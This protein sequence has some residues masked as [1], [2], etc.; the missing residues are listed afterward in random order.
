[1][2]RSKKKGI[3]RI[4]L[5]IL[6]A[7]LV[8]GLA[9]MP[10][11]AAEEEEDE[12]VASILSATATQSQLSTGIRGGGT[13][14]QQEAV[15]VSIPYDVLLTEFLV[16]NGDTVTEGQAVA[17]ADRV[18]VMSAIAQVQET[19]DYLD[20]EIQDARDSETSTT[21]SAASGGKVKAIYAQVGDD[22]QD[23]M[24]QY[25]ALAVLSLDA[26]MAVDIEKNTALAAG[27]SVVVTLPDESQV[28][29]WVES[30]L[31]GKLTVTLSDED[32]APGTYVLVTTNDGDR[33]GAGELY[34]HNAWYA[35]A[36]SGTVS[37]ISVSENATVSSGRT[38][39]TL[40]DTDYTA[41]FELL[42]AQRREY[43]EVMLELFQLYQSLEVTT[44]Q[45][46]VI[47]GVEEN[48]PSLLSDF[49][50]KAYLSLLA[51]AP[52]GDDSQEYNNYVTEVAAVGSEDW[53]LYVDPTNYSITDYKDLSGL[54]VDQTAMTELILYTCDAPIYELDSETGEWKQILSSDIG[55]GDVLLFAQTGE[56][57][58]VWIVRVTKA[59]RVD[60][61][62]D[63]PSDDDTSQ[64][65]PS[66]GGGMTGVTGGGST[67][68]T[69]V[70]LYSLERT[71][72][73]SVTGRET[74]TLSFSVDEMD[75]LDIYLGQS[76]TVQVDALGETCS[77]YVSDIGDTGESS[78]GNSKFTVTVT[79]DRTETMW[80][81][82]SA[83]V[84]VPLDQSISGL[85]IPV[86]ALNE[87]GSRTY[88]YT[89]YDEENGELTDPVEVQTGASDGEWV[90]IFSGLEEGD[91]IWYAYYDTL[92]I[93]TASAAGSTSGF[94]F[95]FGK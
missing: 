80:D 24:A 75:I 94:S 84:T 31:A 70:T 56:G 58:T 91:T 42:C 57:A 72:I 76:V 60:D 12:Y 83:T 25:G 81:G 61:G 28:T 41:Q 88:V 20:D 13:L 40:K 10:L 77:A 65:Q 44:P 26:M 11:L 17:L 78:G 52:N 16:S 45:T 9:V 71:V 2:N 66:T 36:V 87:S 1:M 23:V 32:Y 73:L 22:V 8:A 92:D 4:F 49:G 85:L 37:Y 29:G 89:G 46:G 74:M 55:E 38:L 15:E 19:L 21:V 82:M 27:D 3:K 30:N 63:Q 86:E 18:S 14:A 90:V 34:I 51:N 95:R 93:S 48:S 67:Q 64:N 35:T 6:T 53:A 59:E 50:G 39:M 54:T 68:E 47:S 62:Q 69:V 43:E 33:I 79:L 7:L 5:L